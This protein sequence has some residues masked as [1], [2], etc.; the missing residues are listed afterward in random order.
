[1]SPVVIEPN[2]LPSSP[3]FAVKLNETAWSWRA[4]AS[5]APRSAA[6][7]ASRALV[8]AAMRFLLPS[9]AS[10]A[11]PRGRRKFRA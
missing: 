10:K 7:T 1:M 9:V 4:N 6:A 11:R 5:A 2:N 8:S 3:A